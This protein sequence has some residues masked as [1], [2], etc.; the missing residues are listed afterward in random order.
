MLPLRDMRTP[1]KDTPE[2]T[3]ESPASTPTPEKRQQF[4]GTLGCTWTERTRKLSGVHTAKREAP[5]HLANVE[6]A[7]LDPSI[8]LSPV[9]VA[10]RDFREGLLAD[11]GGRDTVTTAQY[12]LV[13][14]AAMSWMILS[15]INH[16][17]LELARDGALISKKRRH[18]YN[19]VIQRDRL[20]N[21][22]TKTLNVLGLKRPEPRALTITEAIEQA[23]QQNGAT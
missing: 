7:S 2:A 19:C 18:V 6:L 4:G 14:E 13:N 23:K 12:A 8:E 17:L 5:E 16:Y 21:S 22:L 3:P 20:S 9:E 11:L 1:V 10:V 15:S